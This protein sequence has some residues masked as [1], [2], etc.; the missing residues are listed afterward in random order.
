MHKSHLLLKEGFS[1]SFI[2]GKYES[3]YRHKIVLFN[4]L[5]IFNKGK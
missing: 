5:I 1:V 2:N 4:K 3:L